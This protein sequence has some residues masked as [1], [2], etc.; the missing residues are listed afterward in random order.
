VDV[1]FFLG[2]R[3]DNLARDKYEEHHLLVNHVVDKAGEKLG[4]V[5]APILVPCLQLFQSDGELDIARPSQSLQEGAD[6]H[7]N[8]GRDV[9]GWQ[10]IKVT[11]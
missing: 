6:T 8:G 1:R 5:A 2:A 7:P 11:G 4:L 3:Q 9:E 10:V